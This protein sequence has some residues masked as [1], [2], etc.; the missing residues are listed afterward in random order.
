MAAKDTTKQEI[1][2]MGRSPLMELIEEMGFPQ[3]WENRGFDQGIDKTLTIMKMLT[4]NTP[5]EMIA[6][7]LHIPI[8]KVLTIQ[9][10]LIGLIAKNPQ[11]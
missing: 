9:C 5:P 3:E 8:E 6:E 11:S 7:E 10:S 2:V 1:K 4:D